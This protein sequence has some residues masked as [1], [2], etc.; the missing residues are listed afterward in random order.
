MDWLADLALLMII[1]G[2]VG[3]GTVAIVIGI[4]YIGNWNE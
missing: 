3:I 1:A 2:V 4:F